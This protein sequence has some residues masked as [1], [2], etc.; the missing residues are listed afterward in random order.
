MKKETVLQRLAGT[1]IHREPD[2]VVPINGKARQLPYMVVRTDESIKTADGG[3]V[4]Y[5][6]TLWTV[7]LFTP[8]RDIALECK[9][10]KALATAG[11]AAEITHYPDGTPYQTNFEFTT[12][13]GG[14]NNV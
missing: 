10:F 4:F 8:E 1:A 9:I 2:Y 14:L 5:T 12:K 3:R 11:L 13:S 6:E 7:A